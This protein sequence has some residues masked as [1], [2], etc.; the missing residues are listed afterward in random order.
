MAARVRSFEEDYD[1]FWC[2]SYNEYAI[3]GM[4]CLFKH[5]CARLV[6]ISVQGKCWWLQNSEMRTACSTAHTRYR[7]LLNKSKT[8]KGKLRLKSCCFQKLVFP[9]VF[10]ACYCLSKLLISWISLCCTF[11]NLYSGKFK[12]LHVA[13]TRRCFE[14]QGS[15]TDVCQ[16][17]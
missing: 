15:Q 8:P 14:Q 2:Q 7:S 6:G 13:R 3:C 12:F 9:L 11:I 5:I 4:I 10:C 17:L 1:L 16:R